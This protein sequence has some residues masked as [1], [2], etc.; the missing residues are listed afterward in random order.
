MAWG[1]TKMVYELED[2]SK[3]TD[4]FEGWPETLITSCLQKV[5][6]KVYVTDAAQPRSALAYVGCF[7]FY[8]GEP[9]RELAAHKLGGF[10]IMTPQSD[11]WAALIEECWPLAKK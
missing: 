2:T 4:L 7:A 10:V 1:Q 9:D 3:A 6:G 11:E 8:G 5:M